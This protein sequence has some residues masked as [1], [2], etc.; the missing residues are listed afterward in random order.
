MNP[1]PPNHPKKRKVNRAYHLFHLFKRNK[2]NI[3]WGIWIIPTVSPAT[4]SASRYFRMLYFFIIPQ[5][6]KS[7]VQKARESSR[8]HVHFGIFSPIFFNTFVNLKVVLMFLRTFSWDFFR[9]WVR[10]FPLGRFNSIKV[11]RTSGSILF[12][13]KCHKSKKKYY[14]NHTMFLEVLTLFLVESSYL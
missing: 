3:P 10:N 8:V 1:P 6:G 5:N 13:V 7:S 11:F 2:E 4:R 9:T 12:K 14:S